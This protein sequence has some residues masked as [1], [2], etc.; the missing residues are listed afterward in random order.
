MRIIS[1]G[2]VTTETLLKLNVLPFLAIIDGKT[3][4]NF[5]R[6]IS[7]EDKFQVIRIRNE[8]GVIRYT[9]LQTIKKL[10]QENKQ[11]NYLL[12]VDGEEDLLTIPVILY[13]NVNDVILYGQPNAGVVV[14]KPN[15]IITWI[16][17]NIISKMITKLC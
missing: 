3:K 9:A 6:T 14:I 10:L 1:I 2:D 17:F 16:A 8:A 5:I 11:G 7:Y 4:R 15:E 12:L 13:S